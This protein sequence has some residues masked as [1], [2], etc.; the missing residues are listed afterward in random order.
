MRARIRE[1]LRVHYVR[2]LCACVGF[3]WVCLSVCGLLAP[4]HPVFQTHPFS[5]EAM[6][7]GGPLATHGTSN[8]YEESAFYL[9]IERTRFSTYM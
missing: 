9:Y 2:T 6:L 5:V 7:T 3:I 1:K 4:S 8:V